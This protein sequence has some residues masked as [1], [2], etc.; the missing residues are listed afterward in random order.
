[1]RIPQTAKIDVYS[2]GILLC[3][4]TKERFPDEES[5]PSMMKLIRDKWASMHRLI[6]SCIQHHP[7]RQPAM[8]YVLGE[9]NKL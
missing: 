8:S 7:Y 6:N 4:V 9:L 5:I 1:M 2:Y 3:E